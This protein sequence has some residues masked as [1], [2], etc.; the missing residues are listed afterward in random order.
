MM[1]L[2]QVARV[3]HG[4]MQGN[5]TEFFAVSHDTRKLKQ[6]DLYIAL[7]GPNFDGHDFLSQAQTQG[8]A[9]ALVSRVT[10]TSLSMVQVDNTLQALGKLA[11]YWRQQFNVPVIAV[12]GS[13]GKTTVKGMIAAIMTEVGPGLVTQG[14]LNN[15]IGV[16]LT[17]LRFRS[18]HQYGVIEMGMNH[19]G[20]IEYLTRLAQPSVALINNAGQAHLAGLGSVENVARAKGEIFAGLQPDGVAIINADDP[21]ADLWRDLAKPYHCVSFGIS[22]PAE[23]AATYV[24]EATA[25]VVRLTTPLGEISLRLSLLGAHNVL[26]ILAAT[27]ASVSAGATLQQVQKGLENLAAVPG[28]LELKVGINGARV[29][30]DTY[31]AN[32][33]SLTAGLMVL[34]NAVGERILVMGDMAE[35]GESA[36]EIHGDAGALARKLGVDSLYTLGEMTKYTSQR[37]GKGA[38]HFSVHA[39]LIEYLKRV[40]HPG[41]I[42]LVKGSRVMKMEQVVIGITQGTTQEK[43]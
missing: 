15:D 7:V 22:N 3:L 4:R 20:E 11:N 24:T 2:T 41:A 34:G 39:D 13:N 32:P 12:T 16:P 30:D 10:S 23:Y 1:T 5:D 33:G 40:M 19:A 28:R 37:F 8:A 18:K 9:A 17:L 29:L 14:N 38:K 26:N 42:V 6:G 35:L 31:N 43:S 21:Y 36:A 25:C 27:A